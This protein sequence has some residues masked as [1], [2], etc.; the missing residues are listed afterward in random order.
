MRGETPTVSSPSNSNPIP[1][2]FEADPIAQRVAD[3]SPIPQAPVSD[4]CLTCDNK[5]AAF[6]NQSTLTGD[7]CGLRTRLQESGITFGGNLTQFGFGIDGGVQRRVLP[8]L[9]P[10]NNF[11]YTGRGEY[12]TRIDLEKFGGMPKGTLLIRAQQWFGQYGNV[13]PNVGS[14]PPAIFAAAIPPMPNDPGSLFLTDFFVTQPLSKNWVVF[15]GKKNVLGA[16][17][18][19]DFA[20]GNGTSQFLNQAFVANPAFLLGLPYTSFTAGVVSP[21][22]W[23]GFSA[24]VYD[25]QDRTNVFFRP[26][27]LFSKGVIVGGE[28]KLKTNFFSLPGEQHIGGMWKH[29]ATDGPWFS[30]SE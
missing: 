1:S 17:D 19:D 30:H 21:R 29:V 9:P 28:V 2:A 26:N 13:T 27:D 14:F 7:W 10:G 15:A 25:P 22:D 5:W 3:A 6:W 16:A 12:E 8:A 4:E 20:G 23:G 11:Q 18:Q 24:F